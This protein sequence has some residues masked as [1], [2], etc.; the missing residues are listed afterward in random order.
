LSI[1]IEDLQPQAKNPKSEATIDI[2]A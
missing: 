1:N 2:P